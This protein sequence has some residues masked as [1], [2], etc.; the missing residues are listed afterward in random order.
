MNGM[1]IVKCH[2]FV[3][4]KLLV[5]GWIEFDLAYSI[6][7]RMIFCLLKAKNILKLGNWYHLHKIRI[8]N[9]ISKIYQNFFQNS[10]IKINLVT[11]ISKSIVQAV[12]F[13]K[14]K[15]TDVTVLL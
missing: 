8:I 6:S 2:K 5:S 14:D 12:E 15:K 11:I 7:E 4:M 9:L 1:N 13:F 3:I 10:R